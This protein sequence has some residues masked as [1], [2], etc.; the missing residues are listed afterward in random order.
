MAGIKFDITGDNSNVL[1]AF[2]GVQDGV[3]RTQQ[4]VESSGKSIED[5]FDKIK[6]LANTAFVGFTAKEFI[7]TLANVRG[8]FQ[9]LEVAFNTMLGSK[10]KADALMGQLVELAATTPFDLK[11]VASGAKQLLAYGLEAEKVTDTMRRLGDIAAGLGLQIGDLA[12]L[13]GTTLT[14]GRMY[15][16]DL[17]Q[18]TGRGI[19]MIA[20]LAKQFGVAESEVKQLVTEGKVGFPQVE[21]AIKSLT[22][23]GGKFGGLMEAQSHTIIGQ[24]SN[25]KDSIDMAFN[26]MGQQSEGL[27]NASLSVVSFLVEHWRLVGDAIVTAAG[28]VGL[29][30]AQM[31]AVSAI[32]TAT[33]NLGYDAEIA[34]LQ[35]IV[36]LKQQAASTDLQEAVANGSLTQ[37]KAEHIAAMRE[38]AAAYVTELQQ[39]AAAAQASYNEATAIAAQRALELEAAEDKVSACQQ[40][41]DAALQL[42]D[43]TKIATAEENLNIAA[44]ERN[45]AA[46]QLQT[47]RNNVA[48]ASKAAETA[49]T[50]ANTAAQTLNTS[51]VA[52]DTAAKGVWASVVTLCKRVQD[53]WNASMLSSPLFWIAAAIA[54]ATYAVYKLVTAE[55]A[56]EKAI[57]KTNEAWD[58]F[59][60]KLQE[61]QSKIESLI[62]TIQDETA[63]EFQQ[64]EAYQQLSTLAPQLTD[65]Y[66]QAA[67]ATVDFADAQKQVA[68][69]IDEA[70]YDKVK[71]KVEEYTQAVAKW[72][73]QIS[74]D[75]RYNGGKNAMFLS[76]QLEQSQS[77]LDQ[78]ES[79]LTNIIYLRKQAEEDARPIEVRLKEAEDNQAVRQSIF[80]FYDHAITLVSELQE[81]NENINYATGQSNLDEFVANAE[82]KLDEL[83]K[84]QEDNP[85]DLNLRL[86][87]QEKTKILNSIISMKNEWEANGSLVIPFTFQADY[88][89]AQTALNNAKKRF[90]YLT[91]QYENT[92]TVADEVKTAR[93]NINKLTADIQ[94]L[95]KGTILPELGKTVEKS[96]NE[97][98][99]ELQSAQR[100]LETLTGQKPQTDKQRQSSARKAE[101]ERKREEEKRKRAQEQLNKDLLSL[102]Q[103]NI[104]DGI[105]LQKEGTN[106][107]LAEIDNDYKKRIAEIERQE[108]EFKKK[109]KEAGLQGL[110]SEGLTKEQQNALQEATDNAAKER[111]RQ[112]YE[113]YAAEA[114]AMRDY[115]KE[116]GTFQQQKLA[117]AEEYAEKIRNAQNEGERRSLTAERDR[118]LQQTEINAIKQNID[119]GSVF[120]D[121]GTMFRDQLQPTIDRL[122]QIANSDTFKQSSLDEQQVL[123]ELI[124]KLENANAAW[125]SDIFKRVSD[126]MKAYQEAM[127][128]YAAAVDKARIAE[129]KLANAQSTLDAAKRGGLS[130]EVINAAQVAVGEAQEAFNTASEEVKGFGTQVQETTAS[131]NSSATEAKAMFDG[132]AEGLRGLSSGSLQGIGQGIMSL[133]KLFGGNITKDAG[134]ALAKGFQ[135][136]L[137]KD[138]EAAKT[139]SAALGDSGLAGEIISAILGMLDMLAEGGIG[140]IA[141]NLAD[142]V[143]GSVNG[144]LS[145]IF[146]GGIIAKP[147]KS[148]VDGLGGILDTVTFG[149]FSSWGNNVAETKETIERLTVRNEALIDSLD[150]LND[151]MK[152]ANGAAESVA[153]AEQAKEYQQEV[154]ENYRDI[155]AAQ[156]H[157]Q[158][159][160]HS[161]SKYFNDWLEKVGLFDGLDS[162]VGNKAAS[163]LGIDDK[164][165][166]TWRKMNEIAGFEIKSR[167]DFLSITP[168]QMAEMLADVDIRGLI[169]SIGKGGYGAKMLDTLEDYADQA[170]KIEEIENT[171]RETLTQ[172][173][174]DSMY[175]SFID[176]LMD[177]DASADDFA[178]DFSE[179]MMRA[180]LSNQ[181]GTMFKDRLQEWYTAFAEAMEDGDLA[182]GELDSL[183][184]EWDKIVADAMAERDKLAEATG[185]DSMSS[186]ASQQQASKGYSTTMS[187]DTGE[188]L[189]GRFTAMYEAD[190]KIIAIFTD[191]VTTISTLSSVATDCNT[192]L[193]NILNQQVITNSHLENIAKY[194]KNILD[195]G[196]KLD[197]IV[198]NTKNI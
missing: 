31:L 160:H 121:F 71:N 42:G 37:A 47:A 8:E 104:D 81:G 141:S 189:Y 196:N 56:H 78:W 24:I 184:N 163:L 20:E 5:V 119:W 140:G 122:R 21:Q 144:I 166:E 152:E 61:R 16:E 185:Y 82:E 146:S 90:N 85:M 173:S 27:I 136:L 118:A 91:G 183:R 73:E 156:A 65:K 102:E 128:G 145:D 60:G 113:V 147:V 62:R 55:T 26:E 1:N 175:D 171:L 39:K 103:K 135:S 168:E 77:A 132:L 133:D 106:K 29:Y 129:E 191:A 111:E 157:Y 59:N 48:T 190:L 68:A 75:L 127:R 74:S 96:I 170:G 116:Y 193:R 105:A 153:A 108:A 158:G 137:G 159:K 197:M 169:E 57:R 164:D 98:T 79:K 94:G 2:R 186:S 125:D 139:L 15:T 46:K 14:Q 17:N 30:K 138:S 149:G 19:P 126:D 28:A 70:K 131:L 34:Q 25:I 22:D 43:A 161:W 44:V 66:S 101:N 69:S 178:D 187:Q 58:E 155:A 84:K 54:G 33:A 10:E 151:T 12:W 165:L 198:T 67:L 41:Y 53:A 180:L 89:S 35:K 124:N 64:A 195:F 97:K 40:A 7:T 99:K 3:R 93:E 86:E 100:T 143:L 23:E 50:E 114:Q 87:E 148:L 167:S 63:T 179:Y 4:V 51:K 9:Q 92:A 38:E 174:F 150:R 177:M 88:K 80:D 192:E 18:F 83:R 110:N 6:S 120:G 182:S 134:N 45:T 172:I 13:Y 52:A 123:Y 72:K 109:N 154:N 32:N 188:A 112:T 181:V 162:V 176:T 95:R 117:I 49:A 115:L 76:G 107:R 11:G 194:T 130:Q 142:T 36:Q